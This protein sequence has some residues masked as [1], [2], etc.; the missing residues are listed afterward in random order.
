VALD[1]QSIEKKDFPVGSRGYDPTAVDAHLA[2]LA[3]EIEGFKRTARQRTDTLAAS[4]SERVRAIVEAAEKSA[5]EIERAAEEEAREIRAEASNEVRVAREQASE[6]ARERVGR[7]SESANTMLQR[8]D[9][10]EQELTGLIESLR[11]GASRLNTDLQQLQSELASVGDVAGPRPRFEHETVMPGDMRGAEPA[12]EAGVQPG[13][14]SENGAP[15]AQG[16]VPEAAEL[17]EVVGD[18]G[19]TYTADAPAGPGKGGD[20]AEGARLIALN[21]ALDGT[22][23][24]ETARYLSENFQLADASALLDEVYASVDG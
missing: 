11:T 13:P 23:R 15:I 22:P 4:A 2:A 17:R 1:R 20:D 24:E 12:P 21:M 14:A 19:P 6:Q 5:A 8:L 16:P 18:P 10:M 3:D 9:S 7:I